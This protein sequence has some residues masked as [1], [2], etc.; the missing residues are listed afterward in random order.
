MAEK[1]AAFVANEIRSRLDGKESNKNFHAA[2]D[3]LFVALG[4]HYAT[5][6]LFNR[7]KVSGK[8]AYIVKKIISRGYRLGLEIKVNAGYKKRTRP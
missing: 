4:G 5:G 3:G 6:I 8:I 1:S 2:M 7:I